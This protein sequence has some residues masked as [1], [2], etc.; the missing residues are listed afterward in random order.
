MKLELKLRPLQLK[1][2]DFLFILH[3][4]SQNGNLLEQSQNVFRLITL[5]D[6][7]RFWSNY[8]REGYILVCKY[9]SGFKKK[10]RHRSFTKI[11]ILLLVFTSYEK[12]YNSKVNKSRA[13]EMSWIWWVWGIVREVFISPLIRLLAVIGL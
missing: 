4:I 6:K 10:Y 11:F 1:T 9:F 8:S 3:A 13:K 2:L 7:C 12:A 5:W